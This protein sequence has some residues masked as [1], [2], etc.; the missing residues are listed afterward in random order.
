M[1]L[2]GLG[3]LGFLLLGFL[4]LSALLGFQCFFSVELFEESSDYGLA[5]SFGGVEFGAGGEGAEG[6]VGFD[7][8]DEGGFR[9]FEAGLAVAGGAGGLGVAGQ[10]EAGDLEAV[11]QEAGALG[12][13]LVGGDA[14][15]D[16]ADGDLDGGAVLGHG[17]GEVGLAGAAV[18]EVLDGAAG[19]V[20]VVAKLFVA[21]AWAAATVALGEDVAA[22][23]A[24]GGVGHDGIPPGYFWL[25]SLQ[26]KGPAAGLRRRPRGREKARRVPG[27]CLFL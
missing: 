18:G 13:D 16:L 17:E 19:G 5:S 6:G 4:L 26:K 14:E 22:L 25:Q 1:E 23:E 21:K 10:V 8:F 3:L 12:V 11:E 7:V 20:V 9:A 24:L 15:Q 2:L 27:F